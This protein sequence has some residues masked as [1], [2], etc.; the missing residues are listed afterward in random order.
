MDATVITDTVRD[1]TDEALALEF[2]RRHARRLRYVD[3]WSK[4]MLYDGAVWAPD[5]TL[6]VFSHARA[7]CRDDAAAAPP[8]KDKARLLSAK[9]VA[10]V[11]TLA[12]SDPALAAVIDQWDADPMALNCDGEVVQLDAD[13]GF[14]RSAIAGDY[15]TR[16]TAVKPGGDCPLWL[17]FLEL[18]TGGD[19]D[20]IDYLQRMC[21]YCLTGLTV[22]HALFFMWGPGGNGK[23]TFIDTITGVMG[24]YAKTAG[25]DTFTA[26]LVRPPPDR[27]RRPAGRAPG[28]RRRNLAGQALGRDPHQDA[29]RRRSRQGP[30]HAP[31][32]LRVHAAVQAC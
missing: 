3:G 18:V 22:E 28:H 6:T 4:W 10:A 1:H 25:I 8:K 20:L 2:A 24:D 21:G 29:D 5:E 12:R 13:G 15:F 27:Y 14:H 26:H 17:E 23:S 11:V 32:L 19:G 7:L 30:L 9:T 16:S 31:G